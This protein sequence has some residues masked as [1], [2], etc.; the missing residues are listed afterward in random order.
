MS[1][2]DLTFRVVAD[3]QSFRVPLPSATAERPITADPA[4]N[5]K[6]SLLELKRDLQRASEAR[7]LR[8]SYRKDGSSDAISLPPAVTWLN[9]PRADPAVEPANHQFADA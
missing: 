9:R 8:P 3:R 5:L 7:D 1:D 2:R 6:Q 4:D